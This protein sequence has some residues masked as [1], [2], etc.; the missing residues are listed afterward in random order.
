MQPSGQARLAAKTLD[1][2]IE[3]DEDFLR[4]VFRL[5][6]VLRH[7]QAQAIDAP[8]M[9]PV[10]LLKGFDVATRRSLRQFVIRRAHRRADGHVHTARPRG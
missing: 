3:M 2:A 1:L 5:G 7:T 6:H 9:Q 4:Q 10:D 8:V